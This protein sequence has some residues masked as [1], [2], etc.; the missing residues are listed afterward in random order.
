M[1]RLLCFF[2]IGEPFSI[3]GVG[4]AFAF[5]G[6]QPVAAFV[7]ALAAFGFGVAESA[8]LRAELGGLLD[9]GRIGLGGE[10]RAYDTREKNGGN[11]EFEQLF[12][13]VCK[14]P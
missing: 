4:F 13:S 8:I 1:L 14:I 5:F 6:D 12:H 2:V 9:E 11:C 7:P 10:R 3:N